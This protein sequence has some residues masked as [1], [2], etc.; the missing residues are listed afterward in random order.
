M[1]SPSSPGVIGFLHLARVL[2]TD[3]LMR[4]IVESSMIWCL[5]KLMNDAKFGSQHEWRNY[6]AG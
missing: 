4:N 2:C 1:S 6:S 5:S 3:Q